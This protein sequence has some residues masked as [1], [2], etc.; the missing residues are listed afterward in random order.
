MKH[1][2]HIIPKHMGGTDDPE[3]LIE[4]T[5]EE[6][7]EAHRVLYEQHNNEYDRIAWLSLS[8]QINISEAKKLAQLEGSKLGAKI[9]NEIRAQKGNDIGSWNKE[10]GHVLT[11]ATPE[12]CK[13]G[14]SIA[15][16]KLVESGK[17]KEIQSLG[18]KKGGKIA[19]QI[20]A[21]QKWKCNEC[22]FVSTPGG[23]GN[24]QRKTKHIGKEKLL[25]QS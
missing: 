1:I 10:T 20:V 14:G 8:G 22:D 11:I 12:S 21:K 2:H 6:H 9:T 25:C 17:W 4:L 7:A 19:S 13:K 18:G 23:V 5:I 15:G 16:K 24:H 3:N